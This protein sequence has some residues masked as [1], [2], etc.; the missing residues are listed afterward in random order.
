[1]SRLAPEHK[2]SWWK[3]WRFF[4]VESGA[5]DCVMLNLC[6]KFYWNSSKAWRDAVVNHR[7][8]FYVVHVV[9]GADKFNKL[10]I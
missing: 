2:I 6:F 3:M 1:M 10:K 5:A 8:Y 9:A 4:D 7:I